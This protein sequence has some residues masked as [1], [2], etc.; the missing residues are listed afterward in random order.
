MGLWES[1]TKF[2]SIISKLKSSSRPS[3]AFANTLPTTHNNLYF[4]KILTPFVSAAKLA[5]EIPV[6]P[7]DQSVSKHDP[8]KIEFPGES[9]GR[10]AFKLEY[11][12]SPYDTDLVLDKEHNGRLAIAD[13][14]FTDPDITAFLG[15]LSYLAV[16][17]STT[18]T[19][20]LQFLHDCC[21]TIHERGV[22]DSTS[23]PDNYSDFGFDLRLDKNN[24][25]KC[26]VDFYRV[27]LTR[28]NLP[29]FDRIADDYI[30]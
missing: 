28:A 24:R 11:Y 23:Y 22:S 27:Q 5:G 6:T 14:V 9:R 20:P 4:I 10:H 8:I 19:N 26:T 25:M 1:E 12:T 2:S 7:A 13:S 30:L 17:F 3:S 21:L 16:D 15:E 18:G 29:F